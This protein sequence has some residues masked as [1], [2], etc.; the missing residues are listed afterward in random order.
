V[1]ILNPEHLFDQADGLASS[2]VGRPRQVDIRRAISACYYGL[3]HAVIAAAA[4]LMIGQNNRSQPSYGLIYRSI[5]HN[6]LRDFCK[7]VQKP[8][9][10][11]RYKWY[12][13][14]AGFGADLKAF[15]TALV[16]LQEKR[17]TADY[18]PMVQ[19]KQSDAMLLTRTARAA[20]TKFQTADV[21]ERNMFL[22]LL[23]FEPRKY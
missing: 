23:L 21:E 6:R 16:E 5:D 13:P 10:P 15:A 9:L 20:L 17:H 22:T 7:D 18:D 14:Q 8:T 11:D 4:D 19:M 3:F 1:A 12:S 2:G